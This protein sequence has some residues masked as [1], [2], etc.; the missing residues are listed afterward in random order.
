MPRQRY[1]RMIMI[2]VSALTAATLRL[3]G[4]IGDAAR[5]EMQHRLE[6]LYDDL[7]FRPPTGYPVG[8][9]APDGTLVF[10]YT[11]AGD[12]ST[13]LDYAGYCL[14]HNIVAR[15]RLVPL[16][17]KNAN[18]LSLDAYLPAAARDRS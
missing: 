3:E 4:A 14:A 13:P 7:G 10:I 6:D 9:L 12:G 8:A 17:T 2:Q 11:G 15:E 1:H 16:G 18:D 5:L